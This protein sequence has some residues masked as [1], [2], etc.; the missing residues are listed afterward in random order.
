LHLA[1]DQGILPRVSSFRREDGTYESRPLEDMAPFLPRE[2]VWHNMHLFD[3]DDAAV[4]PA[5][6]GLTEQP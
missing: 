1:A 6:H 2:E 3:E 4:I 5:A